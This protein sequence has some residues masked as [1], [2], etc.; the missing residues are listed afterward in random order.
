MTDPASLRVAD[1]IAAPPTVPETM[2]A[3]EVARRMD[4]ERLRHVLVEAGGQLRGLVDRAALLR[5]LVTHY[6]HPRSDL[7]ISH[8]VLRDP[9]TI[10]VEATA[11]EAIALMRRHRI[12]SLPVMDGE[13]LVGLLSERRL[14]TACEP[15]IMRAAQPQSGGDAWATPA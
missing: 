5:H 3:F 2:P 13:R 8:F 11:A 1:L 14:L 6:R 9:I 10:G 12:G 7:P 15:L 4:R